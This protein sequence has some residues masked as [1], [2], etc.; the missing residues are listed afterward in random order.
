MLSSLKIESNILQCRI[1]IWCSKS[2]CQ[3]LQLRGASTKQGRNLNWARAKQ[4]TGNIS[5]TGSSNQV[6]ARNFFK[7]NQNMLVYIKFGAINYLGNL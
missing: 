2:K 5:K 4:E 7:L 1:Y 3:N 6:P